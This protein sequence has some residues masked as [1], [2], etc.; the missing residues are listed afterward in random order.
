MALYV[1]ISINITLP[2]ISVMIT[3]DCLR[4][5]FHPCSPA[6]SPVE[7]SAVAMVT[8]GQRSPSGSS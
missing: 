5:V 3:V 4:A 2:F 8:I 7:R 6:A 1:Y